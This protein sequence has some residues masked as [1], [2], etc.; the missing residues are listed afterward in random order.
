VIGSIKAYFR[1]R[2]LTVLFEKEFTDWT[3]EHVLESDNGG[4]RQ[5]IV[6][7]VKQEFEKRLIEA[8]VSACVVEMNIDRELLKGIAKELMDNYDFKTPIQ[9]VMHDKISEYLRRL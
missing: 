2:K 4:W 9:N 7:H 5:D 8:L 6:D 1:A 3:I